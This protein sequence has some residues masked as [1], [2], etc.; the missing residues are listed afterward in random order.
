M[1]NH[2]R[3]ATGLL[4]HYLSM[5]LTSNNIAVDNE[6]RTEMGQI[7]DLIVQAAVN[8]I[9]S[10]L[11][12]EQPQPQRTPTSTGER[13]AVARNALDVA[14]EALGTVKPDFWPGWIV[15]L[16]G[17]MEDSVSPD[18]FEDAIAALRDEF[19]KRVETGNW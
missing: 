1:T 12:L 18:Q 16:L 15:Y 4:V 8:E 14:A 7:V 9:E 6:L 2:K 3:E 17:K 19:Q 11:A 10:K 13:L 5:A